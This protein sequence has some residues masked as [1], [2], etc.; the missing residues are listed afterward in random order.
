MAEL[1]FEI[2]HDEESYSYELSSV[3]KQGDKVRAS[4]T[5][6]AVKVHTFTATSDHEAH[7][8]YNNWHGWGRWK[9]M[10]AAPEYLFT[11]EEVAEQRRYIAK[12][13]AH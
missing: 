11:E 13:K 1:V 2:W 4:M 10:P 7:Q 3:S 5:P 8:K 12:R 9:P 6:Q